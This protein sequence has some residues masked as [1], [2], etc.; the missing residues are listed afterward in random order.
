MACAGDTEAA[1]A[2]TDQPTAVS[3]VY[4]CAPRQQALA[5]AVAMGSHARGCRKVKGLPGV[6]LR[7]KRGCN[8]HCPHRLLLG[9]CSGDHC[10]LGELGASA[11]HGGNRRVG[12]RNGC[13]L[14][15]L[16][17]TTA[18]GTLRS[19]SHILIHRLPSAVLYATRWRY[20]STKHPPDAVETRFTYSGGPTPH[21]GRHFQ[22]K[23]LHCGVVI[24]PGGGRRQSTSRSRSIRARRRHPLPCLTL[25]PPQRAASER[26]RAPSGA[27]RRGAAH[28]HALVESIAASHAGVALALLQR[29]S[30]DGNAAR[31]G[32]RRAQ[33]SEDPA[34]LAAGRWP[35]R[36]RAGRALAKTRA[37]SR[38]IPTG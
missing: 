8:P 13:S 34:P 12:R 10:H 19:H 28:G 24:D 15:S 11:D 3:E 29:R 4:T 14:G 23:S 31:R 5:P 6:A 9:T 36:A 1:V 27:A 32:G 37:V 2:P 33:E 25:R 7:R 18:F 35:L 16:A 38:A 20:Y 30:R 22:A 26:D 17:L 21:V